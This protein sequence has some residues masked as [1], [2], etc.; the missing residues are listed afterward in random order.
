M[1]EEALGRIFEEFQQADTS[2]TRQYG[3]TG[4]GLS[5]SRSLARLLGGDIVVTSAVGTGSTFTLTVP[6]R[7]GEKP[8]PAAT[9]HSARD[10]ASPTV[11]GKPVVLSIDDDPDVLYL[12]QENLA[13]AGYQ[14]IGAHTGDEGVAKAR[15]LKPYA[16]TLDIMMPQKDG[17]QV[18]YDLKSDPA[19]R[20]IPVIMLSIVDKKALGYRLGAADYLLKPLEAEAVLNA[21]KRLAHLNGRA[22]KRLLV[23][24]D[25]PYVHDLARQV[26]GEHYQLDHAPDGVAALEAVQHQRPD[27]IL[28]DLMMPRL[29]GFGVIELLQ[30]NPEYG[31]I[32]IVVITAKTLTTEEAALLQQNV[33]H[34]I[35]KQ[36]LAGE[37]LLR[38]LQ[39]AL[40]QY[41]PQPSSL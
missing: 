1:T 20:D 38:E 31:N 10:A 4:L 23:V 36:G 27:A 8:T 40:N 2:T 7:H 17:W 15:E 33:S 5:I 29:D 9:P 19:T 3:G 34:V 16:I 28:L 26:L 39:S 25:D 30:H 21:L 14:V 35:Q 24:D 32:P 18:L 11:T 41:Q 22:I 13:E 12:L 6:Q 37:T